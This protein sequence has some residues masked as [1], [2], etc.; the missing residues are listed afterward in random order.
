MHLR[1]DSRDAD[2]SRK[3]S[4]LQD[5]LQEVIDQKIDR[6][7]VVWSVKVNGKSYSEKVPHD[8]GR[9][10]LAAI[11]SLEIET[12]SAEELCQAFL[13]R[14]ALI[15]ECL[16]EGAGRVSELFRTLDY[17]EANRQY[18]NLLESCQGFFAMLHESEE[19]LRVDPQ[20][21]GQINPSIQDALKDSSC[22]FDSMLTAQ[23][24][25]DWT[26]LADLLEYELSPLL[27]EYKD[28]IVS[29]AA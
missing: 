2:L 1:I 15:L 14:S 26:I 22:L 19:V 9:V 5:V 24:N 8:A 7:R 13:R 4:N 27:L 3:H 28:I 6:S 17:K 23:K 20:E 11:Q 12:K 10:C 16:S 25:E 21:G 29:R 18:R